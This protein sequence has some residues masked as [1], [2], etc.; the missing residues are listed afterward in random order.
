MADDTSNNDRESFVATM[1]KIYRRFRTP[2][3]ASHSFDTTRKAMDGKLGNLG[4]ADQFL[5]KGVGFGGRTL[6]PYRSNV[7]SSFDRQGR[8]ALYIEEDFDPYANN[9]LDIIADFVCDEDENGNILTVECDDEKKKQILESLYYDVLNVESSIWPTSRGLCKFGDYFDLINWHP[10]HG[11]LGLYPL[12]VHEVER[13][14][15]YDEKEPMAIRFKWTTHPHRRI[16]N[17]EMLHFRLMGNDSMLPYGAC[18]KNDTRILTK[19][20]IKE[21]QHIV[22]GDTVISFNFATQKKIEST[23]LDTVASGEKECYMI[24]T[25]HTFFEASK[26]HKIATYNTTKN[27]FEYKNV[28]ELQ[29]GDKLVVSPKHNVE[30]NIPIDKSF[31]VNN[32]RHWWNENSI[33]NIPDYVTEDFARL[34]GFL[35]GD[36]WLFKNT[37]V[38]ALGVDEQTNNKYSDLLKYFSNK[39]YL[40]EIKPNKKFHKTSLKI[41]KL[42]CY[43]KALYTILKRMGFAGKAKTKRLPSWIFSAK[44]EIQIALLEGLLDADG[45]VFT[46][47]WDCT[48]HTIEL[49]N[50]Q[51]VKDIKTL[52]Q[53][54]GYKSGKVGMRQRHD[55]TI[56][57][58]KVKNIAPSFVLNYYISKLTQNNPTDIANRLTNDFIIEPIETIEKSGKFPTYDICVD[59]KD[60]NFFANGILVHNSVLE[61]SRRSFQ[62][63]LMMFDAMMIYRLVRAPE[64]LVYY[65][66]LGTIPPDQVDTYMEEQKAK[67]KAASMVDS[68]SGIIDNRF[69]P[70]TML[71]DI[72]VGK[73]GDFSSRI[74]QLPGGTIQG[75][76]EDIEVAINRYVSG[77]K[78]PK[79]YLDYSEEWAKANIANLDIRFSKTI[80]RIQNA[81]LQEYTKVGI[82]HLMT[83]G[84]DGNDLFDWS[85]SMSNPSTIAELQKLEMWEKRISL[86]ANAKNTEIIPTEWIYKEILNFSDQDISGIRKG[87][88]KDKM[89]TSLNDK[90]GAK[91]EE[92]VDA[93]GGEE[94]TPPAEEKGKEGEET[95]PKKE[96]KSHYG[97]P[98]TVEPDLGMPDTEEQLK[99]TIPNDGDGIEDPYDRDFFKKTAT[100]IAQDESGGAIHQ[101]SKYM[102]AKDN[103]IINKSS[104]KEVPKV[105]VKT[106]TDRLVE[107]YRIEM[108]DRAFNINEAEEKGTVYIDE[109]DDEDTVQSS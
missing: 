55:V 28:P 57:G 53:C 103:K 40:K 7:A 47:E 48:R 108:E 95:K 81:M 52:I 17:F 21:I 39:L 38:F 104:V 50:E 29:K 19:E 105:V 26:E 102:L 54:I 15:G 33:K 88:M 98:Q 99:R 84:Y 97:I 37:V 10:K 8:I 73:R 83:M 101:T 58:N 109:Y 30:Q 60:H 35:I 70:I 87:L 85:L 31:P 59:N 46:D 12:P 45:S 4:T 18:L 27:A 2:N 1:K 24:R 16:N 106:I 44:K 66:E 23:V 63:Y 64:R 107:T 90:L 3:I 68:T 14:E 61:S 43:S 78:V 94:E 13:E 51:L 80:R 36:G 67:L 11:V 49:S 100:N 82:I 5:Q 91:F 76:T 62:Q 74:E 69:D 32:R 79:P 25:R 56:F 75:D 92:R 93:E 20:G 9:A 72:W 34:F 71:D 86:V 96:S 41:M 22:K 77:L 89:Y 42:E 6:F 65:I